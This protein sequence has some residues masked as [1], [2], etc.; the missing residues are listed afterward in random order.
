MA[1]AEKLLF[2]CVTFC[3]F[4]RN[5]CCRVYRYRVD[6]HWWNMLRCGYSTL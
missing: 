4:G 3:G 6:C 1:S 2:F 5:L